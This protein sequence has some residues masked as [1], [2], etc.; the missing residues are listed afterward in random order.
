MRQ[1]PAPPA[2]PM[3]QRESPAA[4]HELRGALAGL[5]EAAAPVYD[6]M[7]DGRLL[8]THPA[9]ARA[10]EVLARTMPGQEAP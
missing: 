9:V 5:L 1:T 3:P 2:P 4:M 7:R 8:V 6:V 10:R